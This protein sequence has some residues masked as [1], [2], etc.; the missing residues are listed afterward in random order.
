MTGTK[1]NTKLSRV[2]LFECLALANG[3]PK[4]EAKKYHEK[5]GM[6]YLDFTDELD[7]HK[8][9]G[10]RLQ[11]WKIEVKLTSSYGVRIFGNRC[12]KPLQICVDNSW[13]PN[14]EKIS[15][16]DNTS[17]IIDPK[18]LRY[19]ECEELDCMFVARRE[20][21]LRRHHEAHKKDRIKCSQIIMDG[22]DPD[23]LN[24]MK[25]DGIL[26]PGFRETYAMFWDIESLLIPS[27]RGLRHVPVTVALTKNFGINKEVFICR[28]DMSPN[29]LKKMICKF[30]DILELAHGEFKS[31]L[32][33]QIWKNIKR[34]YSLVQKHDRN[35]VILPTDGLHKYRSYIAKLKELTCLKMYSFRGERYDIPVLKGALFDEMLTRDPDFSCIVRGSGIMQF[36]FKSIISRDIGWLSKT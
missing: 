19:Y 10:Y 28:E 25:K 20:P 31:A 15:L 24:E 3:E 35:E 7:F 2:N 36:K 16:F 17:F 23:V 13:D 29:A 5:W 33:I 1:N 32:P 21:E 12:E 11:I 26:P 34:L 6:D 22:S 14:S 9:F 30:L 18:I 27:E 8:M 4:S